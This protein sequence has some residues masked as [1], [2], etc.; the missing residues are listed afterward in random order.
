M[1][2]PSY[3]REERSG[4]LSFGTKLFQ[5]FGA[6]PDTVK[7]W[8]FNTFALLFYNQVL[9]VDALLVS[10]ALAV[11]MVFDAVTDPLVASLSD[12]LRSRW[13][14]RHPLMLIAAL[15]L[16][17]CL[18]AVFVPPQGLGSLSLFAWLLTFTVLTRGFMT[19]YFVPWA[20][21]AAELSD[22]YD[23]RTLIMI[24]RYAVGWTIGV[25]LPLFVY[26]FLMPGTEE[27]PVGQL[28]PEGYPAM[29]ALAGLLLTGGALATTLLTWREI[30]YLRR[31]A[32]ETPGFSLAQ[33][34]RELLRALQNRQFLLIFIAVLLMS[35]IGGTTAN[36]NIYMTTFFWGLTTEDL[37]WF[38]LSATGAVVAFPIVAGLQT[39]WDKKSILLTSGILSLLDGL[40]LVSLRF[41]DV[42]PANGDPMLLVIL[43]GMGVITAGLAVV[44]GVTAS[45]IVAD[46][47]DDHELRTGYRQEAMFSAA[48]SF[49]GKAISGLGTIF[50]G[51]IITGIAFPVGV[52]PA[53]VPD[54][55]ILRLGVAVGVLVPLF[56]L[57][58]IALVTRYRITR[59]RHAEIRAALQ[60]RRP[61]QE[62]D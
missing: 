47:L 39:R 14:R 8:V 20:A 44:L 10:V 1:H 3:I 53:E 23:E 25:S 12:N 17:A 29:A 13:G 34:G 2:E 56:Y 15:P 11:A 58:P 45:S 35:A 48:L 49:S 42:L 62:E 19:L 51:L 54:N 38:A 57:A 43:V 26:T 50:G 31:H 33:T 16:G 32:G 18:F 36:I 7:N 61:L 52:A 5:G 27:Q 22:D 41:L 37:R 6:I 21:I 60:A 30:P 40:F 9:G 46:L 24:F 55:A 59:E 28:N 4:R